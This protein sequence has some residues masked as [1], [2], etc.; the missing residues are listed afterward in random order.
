ML[1]QPCGKLIHTERETPR[2]NNGLQDSLDGLCVLWCLH[3]VAAPKMG[4][5]YQNDPHT[6]SA[7]IGHST[8]EVPESGL[9]PRPLAPN[10]VLLFLILDASFPCPELSMAACGPEDKTYTSHMVPLVPKGKAA[11][12]HRFGRSHGRGQ[13]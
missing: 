11:G 9:K 6:S 3:L 12:A 10:A 2:R 7:H 8:L 1:E 4:A 5:K 13:G